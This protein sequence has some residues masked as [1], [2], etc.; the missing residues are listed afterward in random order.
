MDILSEH[1]ITALIP[2][3][4]ELAL[5]AERNRVARRRTPPRT[6][7]TLRELLGMRAPLGAPVTSPIATITGSIPVVAR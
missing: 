6:R 1:R 4:R 5:A 7:R 2:T 3:E